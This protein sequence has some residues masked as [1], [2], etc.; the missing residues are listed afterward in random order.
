[1]TKVSKLLPTVKRKCIDYWPLPKFPKPQS[2]NCTCQLHETLNI[3]KIANITKS[4]RHFAVS[5]SG[6]Y[7][8]TTTT[9][10]NYTLISSA[11]SAKP[12]YPLVRVLA[13][14]LQPRSSKL[15]LMVLALYY[16]YSRK[17]LTIQYIAQPNWHY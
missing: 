13:L 15:L 10:P 9:E 7:T 17:S 1:M 14:P 4:G 16:H 3:T 2:L 6:P 5:I 8:A 11:A 12:N